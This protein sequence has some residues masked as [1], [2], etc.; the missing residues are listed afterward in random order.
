MIIIDILAGGYDDGT[1]TLDSI[2]EYDATADSFTQIGT[3]TSA[4]DSH[5]MYV[6]KYRDF[7]DWS[8]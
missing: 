7:S 8:E 5:A 2:L 6:V 1:N 3:M 4:R